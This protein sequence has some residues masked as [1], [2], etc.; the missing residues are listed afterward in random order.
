MP[1]STILFLPLL[2][3]NAPTWHES[4]FKSLI[5]AC[6]RPAA[7]WEKNMYYYP[8]AWNR[9]ATPG[10][11][12]CNVEVG[13]IIIPSPPPPPNVIPKGLWIKYWTRYEGWDGKGGGV[14]YSWNQ[15]ALPCHCYLPYPR[16]WFLCTTLGDLHF[17][18]YT[19]FHMNDRSGWDLCSSGFLCSYLP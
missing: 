2:P 14:W 6:I 3:Y 18:R 8:W 12:A 1:V 4:V 5:E 19:H 11:C 15:S 10:I 13:R 7:G 9:L 17:T 16:R